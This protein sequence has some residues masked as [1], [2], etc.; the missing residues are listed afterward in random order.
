MILDITKGITLYKNTY[1]LKV[2]S[3]NIPTDPRIV[4]F[5]SFYMQG[6]V[7]ILYKIYGSGKS[8]YYLNQ[9][10]YDKF[11]IGFMNYYFPY[12]EYTMIDNNIIFNNISDLIDLCHVIKL[13]EIYSRNEFMSIEGCGVTPRGDIYNQNDLEIFQGTKVKIETVMMSGSLHFCINRN[14]ESIFKYLYRSFSKFSY[15]RC[16]INTFIKLF[17]D[18]GYQ[19]YNIM[20]NNIYFDNLSDLYVIY[21]LIKLNSER[22][23][24]YPEGISLIKSSNQ[25]I[26]QNESSMLVPIVPIAKNRKE[27][28][29]FKEFSN[30]YKTHSRKK[31]NIN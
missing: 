19:K 17:I 3:G 11:V 30:R 28:I 22:F 6:S 2:S 13:N 10:D 29:P 27:L 5:K 26:N 20:E 14:S 7:P 18:I 15:D 31:F 25:I 24:L 23:L 12:V 1:T 21:N 16:D 4:E 9:A 8:I